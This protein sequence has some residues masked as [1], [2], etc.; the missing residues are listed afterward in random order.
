VIEQTR[1]VGVA[2]HS[3]SAAYLIGGTLLTGLACE[4]SFRSFQKAK[5]AFSDVM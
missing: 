1:Q 4:L 2:G 5:R 3:P